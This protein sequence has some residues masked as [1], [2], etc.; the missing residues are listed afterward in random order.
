MINTS[1]KAQLYFYKISDLCIFSV[2]MLF[3]SWIVTFSEDQTTLA[4]IFSLRF[5]VIN[6]FGFLGMMFL[7]SFL[8]NSLNLYRSRR[9]EGR[10]VELKDILKAT[11]LGTSFFMFVG[12]ILNIEI[13]TPS[14]LLVFWV[15]STGATMS[16]RYILRYI[17][18]KRRSTGGNLRYIVIVGTNQKAYD[19]SR[20]IEAKK[21]TGY[22]VLGYIDDKIH[23]MNKELELLGKLE[24]FAVIIRKHVVDEVVIILPVKSYY[25]EIQKIIK[26]AEEQGILI[27]FLTE[28][29]YTSNAQSYMDKFED[30]IFLTITSGYK[31]SWQYFAKRIMD[32]L[33]SIVIIAIT[34]PLLLFSIITIKLTSKGPIFFVQN[35]VGYNK[36][37][38][39][40]YKLRTMVEG[41]E[42]LQ[43][44]LSNMNAMDGPVFKIKNDPRV[45]RIGKSLR[46][47]SIDEIP[48][49]V[50]VIK[51]N[52]SMVGPRPLP[53]SDYNK[54]S[55]EFDQDWQRRRFSILPGIT[56][57]W[58]VADSRNLISFEDWMKLDM[59][60]IDNW[61]L[62]NDLKIVLKTIPAAIKGNGTF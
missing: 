46:R 52:M 15:F 31:D 24:E 50:N 16:F 58:Q 54:F 47:W 7:W 4:E 22:R 41:S 25:M 33:L 62:S 51:G 59:E 18:E 19:F 5:K 44:E 43:T 27:R 13:F 38:F 29:F 30:F 34:S 35:R 20:K 37:K 45:T 11:V 9:L 39:R 17:L 36:R 12:Y 3:T 49:F 21:E 14:F 61:K 55:N 53:V 10:F 6:F 32:I 8:F 28:M 57:T 1:R 48:Q 60:Y 2:A 42:N 40:L 56:C 26:E 23:L